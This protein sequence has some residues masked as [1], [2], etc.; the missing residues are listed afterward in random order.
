[1]RP[2]LANLH[3]AW[4]RLHRDRFLA[5]MIGMMLMIGLVIR[6]LLLALSDPLAKNYSVDLSAYHPLISSYFGLLTPALIGGCVAG[7]LILESKEEGP[8]LAIKVAAKARLWMLSGTLTFAFI[9][10]FALSIAMF[11]LMGLP[12]PD[13]VTSGAAVLINALAAT[14][15]ALILCIWSDNK[16]QAFATTKIISLL[17]LIP[18]IAYFSSPPW[19]FLAGILPFFWTCELWWLAAEAQSLQTS[20]LAALG[21]TLAWVLGLLWIGMKRL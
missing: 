10:S 21:C 16:V 13:L 15:F 9:I 6:W 1:M 7:F 4:L 20:L 8:L 11:V 19:R 3:C 2:F 12:F 17:A 14:C 18:V 5:S